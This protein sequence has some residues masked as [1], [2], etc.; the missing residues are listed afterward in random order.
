MPVGTE[1][2]RHGDGSATVWC[3]DYDRATGMKGMHGV[4]LHP[5]RALVELKVRLYN[6]TDF[7][8]TFLWWANAAAKVHEDYQSFFPSDVRY[9]ADHAKRALTT[10]PL[11]EGSYYGV[12]Y[13][14]RAEHGVPE[15]EIPAHFRPRGYPPNDLSR[16][17]NIPV[18][19]SYM[20]VETDGDF[21]GGYDHAAHAGFVH[22]ANHHIAPGKKQWTWGNHEFGYAWDRNLTES[23]GPYVELMAGVYTDNQPD[24]SFL[25]PGETK[26]FSQFWY[27]L[28]K[29]GVPLAANLDGAIRLEATGDVARVSLCVTRDHSSATIVLQC[30]SKMIARWER[31]LTVECG[32]SETI[33]LPE[34]CAPAA[35]TASLTTE[36]GSVLSCSLA[37]PAEKAKPSLAVEPPHPQLV[38][39]TDQLFLIGLHLEQYRHVT[40]SP[41]PYWREALRRDPGDT[42]CNHALAKLHLKRGEYGR[43]EAHLRRAIE[44]ATSMNPNPRDAEIFYTLGLTLRL[45][46]RS[47]EAYAA[48]Y[49]ATWDAAWRSPAYHAVAEFDICRGDLEAALQ[50]LQLSLQTNTGNLNARNLCVAVMRRLGMDEAASHLLAQTRSLDPLDMWSR[51]L[52]G[53]PLPRNG[54]QLLALGFL[55]ERAGLTEDAIQVLAMADVT[56]VDGSSP[57]LHMATARCF[58]T[59]GN[60]QE[61]DRQIQA[62]ADAPTLYCFPNGPDQLA[63]LQYA[64]AK[65]PET[66]CFHYYLGNLLFH[67]RRHSEAIEAWECAVKFDASLAQAWRNLGIAYFNEKD[68]ADAAKRAFD[69]A[70]AAAPADG[71]ILYERDQ[72]EKRL[73]AAPELRLAGLL[74][75]RALIEQRD[76][77]S[78]ELATLFNQIG[79]PAKALDVLL[80]RRF[81]AWE[82]GEGL[83]LAQFTTAHLQLGRTALLRGEAEVA[84]DH[85]ALALTPPESLGEARHLLASS[86]NMYYWL[87]EALMA[88]GDSQEAMRMYERSA[89]QPRDFQDMSVQP[90]SEMTYWTGL[91]LYRLGRPEQARDLFSRLLRYAVNLESET[92]KID[93]F[94]T[95]LPDLLLFDDDLDERLMTHAKLLRASALIGLGNFTE[96]RAL[97]DQVLA[98]DP[99][100]LPAMEL[101]L[102]AQKPQDTPH[103]A[104]P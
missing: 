59:L 75:Y 44:R 33:P 54:H 94:A 7:M 11:A 77:L 57:L 20:V 56:E 16:Y 43:A 26:T 5:D 87:G 71:R 19:T 50:H 39:S 93:Y 100:N 84:K 79:Q 99:N 101:S 12:D 47:D 32:F 10:F 36:T 46:H 48:F 65:K 9:V 89:R 21:F 27:P 104:K 60:T 62:A 69:H 88:C 85:F 2:E 80:G 81:Q 14:A 91:A 25:A 86:S 42:R 61:G 24:F 76:D 70:F 49:K 15:E 28:R 96:G 63:V 29:T 67:Q 68:D 72:L 51:F 45:L 1:I 37:P 78:V 95:S 53:A 74:E 103:G 22:V 52:D 6:G 35:L 83:V 90:F 66:A 58:N 41:E 30:G 38:E 98:A 18:P 8:Q 3:S 4:C 31:P 13:G 92:A 23:D 102:G 34:G 55:L 97:L 17:A 64:I 40:R 73:K 82:G